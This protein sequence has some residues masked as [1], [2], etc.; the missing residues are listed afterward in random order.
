MN[1]HVP[2]ITIIIIMLLLLAAK[3]QT[4]FPEF[5][6]HQKHK[7]E[8]WPVR[9]YITYGKTQRVVNFLFAIVKW[10]WSDESE[11]DRYLILWFLQQ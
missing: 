9:M 2:L 8:H 4:R 3:K 6:A 11:K 5:G 1:S 7:R 10:I